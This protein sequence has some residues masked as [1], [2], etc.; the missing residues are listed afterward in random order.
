[1][2]SADL[3]SRWWTWAASEPEGTNSVADRNGSACRRNQPRDVW[4]LAGTFGTE[5]RRTCAVPNGTPVAFPLVNMIG[6]P[7]EC[8]LFMTTA[9][10][11][12]VVDG[13][14]VPSD[15]HR[16][17][18]I[19]VVSVEGNPVTMTGGRATT[20]GCGLWVQL[21]PLAPGFHSLEISGRSGEFATRVHYAL[22][23]ETA[24]G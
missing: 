7:E 15:A 21:A 22:A 20:T 11:S 3:Q 1:M 10:G 18:R 9:K 8:A 14:P 4:F 24:N 13:E 19:T 5:E 12:A 16:G 2:S 17:D 23:V 6:S